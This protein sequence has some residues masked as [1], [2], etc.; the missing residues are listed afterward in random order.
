MQT[1]FTKEQFFQVF[2][3]YNLEVFPMQLVLYLIA[4]A[5]LYF[6]FKPSVK[7]GGLISIILGALW[8]WMGII[9]HLTYFTAI[10]PAAYLFGALFVAQGIL[11]L[12]KGLFRGDFSF[13]FHAD[14]YG[15]TGII[16]IVY[17]LLIYPVLGSF[18]GHHYPAAP[19]F[20]LPCPTTIFTF[21]LMLMTERRISLSILIIP[22]AWSILGF[23][24]AL[25]FGVMEDMGLLIAGLITVPLLI[26]R[27][28]KFR[29]RH[30]AV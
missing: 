29:V 26:A 17:A 15:I 20:G 18:L 30:V 27:N 21:G 23:T 12:T 19:S 11:F 7:S 9:Y 16:L 14:R 6:S 4:I 2:A 5:A 3:T 13:R 24:A 25:N 22:F 8:L 10:N 28:R 1:P